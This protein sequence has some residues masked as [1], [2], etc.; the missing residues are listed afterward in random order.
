MGPKLY[1]GEQLNCDFGIYS[2]HIVSIFDYMVLKFLIVI[3][4]L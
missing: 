4:S 2:F 3:W 1:W